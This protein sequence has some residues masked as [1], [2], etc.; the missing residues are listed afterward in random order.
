[1]TEN[2]YYGNSLNQNWKVALP[3]YLLLELFHFINKLVNKSKEI[4]GYIFCLLFCLFSCWHRRMNFKSLFQVSA[5]WTSVRCSFPAIPAS[6]MNGILVS[7]DMAQ[8]H[9]TDSTMNRP[10][11]LSHNKDSVIKWFP[12][13]VGS[14]AQVHKST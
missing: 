11:W 7:Q 3:Q 2:I 5:K 14:K 4:A 12:A 13:N 8:F 10:L 6:W 1:M 9:A